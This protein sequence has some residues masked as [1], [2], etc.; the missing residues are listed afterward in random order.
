MYISKHM[1]YKIRYMIHIS[2]I[3]IVCVKKKKSGFIKAETTSY[4]DL[5]EHGGEAGAKEKGKV[6]AS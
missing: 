1:V 6:C 5:V 2:C 3:L 4:T